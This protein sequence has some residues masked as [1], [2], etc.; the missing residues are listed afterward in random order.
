MSEIYDRIGKD[1][2]IK[3]INHSIVTN[4]YLINDNVIDFFRRANLKH[5]Q[6][7]L[8]GCEENHNKTRFLK[9]DHSDTYNK[10]VSNILKTAKELPSISINVRVNINKKNSDELHLPI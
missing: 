7:T 9:A 4:G 1:C 8:D 5:I 3:I 2:K 6:I 10:I